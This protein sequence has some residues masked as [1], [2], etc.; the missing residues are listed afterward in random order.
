MTLRDATRDLHHAVEQTPLGRAMSSGA[1]PATWWSDWI[2]ALHT[3]HTHLDP[4]LAPSLHRVV[5]LATDLAHLP[6]P[7]PTETAPRFALT[8]TTPEARDAAAYVLCGAHLMG[9]AIAERRL[10]HALPCAHLRWP[11]RRAAL[12]AWRPLRDRA[13]LAPLARDTFAALLAISTE[14]APP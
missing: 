3:I 2:G 11:D 7:V 6:E 9:G 13:D 14:I 4:H 10:G 12:D 5:A 1:M 8:L